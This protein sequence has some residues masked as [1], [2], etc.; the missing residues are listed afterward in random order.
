LSQQQVSTLLA[1]C[2]RVEA[3]RA[4]EKERFDSTLIEAQLGP[5]GPITSVLALPNGITVR[6]LWLFEPAAECHASRLYAAPCIKRSSLPMSCSI[7]RDLYLCRTLQRLYFDA[8]HRTLSPLTRHDGSHNN[9][10][11]LDFEPGMHNYMNWNFSEPDH[12]M[13]CIVI[14]MLLYIP[15][16][17][18]PPTA[19]CHL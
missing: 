14:W 2:A 17:V 19:R 11:Y 6:P 13:L 16:Y 5:K 15:A 1:F 12:V 4:R 3:E 7:N 18:M 9:R 8:S 10:D